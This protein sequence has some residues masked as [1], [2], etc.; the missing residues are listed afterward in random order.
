MSRLKAGL[1]GLLFL[2]GNLAL[3]A[4]AGP[5]DKIFKKLPPGCYLNK[6]IVVSPQQLAQIGKKLGVK[7]SK[8]SNT[9]LTVQGRPIQVNILE[10]ES[11]KA[12]VKLHQVISKM[13]SHPAFCLRRGRK[14]IEFVGNDITLATKTSF[15]LGLVKKPKKIRYRLTAKIA[16]IEKA[17]YM[18][19]NKLFNAFLTIN[20]AQ[21]GPQAVAAIDSLKKKNK[22]GNSISMRAPGQGRPKSTYR[23]SPAP[24]TTKTAQNGE[25]VTYQFK[26][27][28]EVFSVPHLTATI[29][30]TSDQAGFTPSKRKASKGLLKANEFWPATDPEI[31]ALAKKITK[32]KR[33]RQAKVAAILKWLRPGSNIKFGGPQ[34]GSRWGVMQVL[35][36]KY[37]HCWDFSD[38][39]VT[40]CRSLGIPSRQVGGWIYGTSGHI[41]AEVLYPGKGWQQVDPTGLACGIY[42]IP[43]FTTENGEMPILYLAMPVIDILKTK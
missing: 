36:Q 42:H 14:V 34:T 38:L 1:I 5:A 7:L 3:A 33:T 27:P 9:F 32:G 2:A 19:L 25:I 10:A 28:A 8:L 18:S 13:K 43:Y 20:S 26:K 37:G 39:F 29:E 21:P 40:L 17:D 16:T 11:D 35:K 31:V 4:G 12:A 41:W 24:T 23:L 22:F 30:I 15:E 6:S